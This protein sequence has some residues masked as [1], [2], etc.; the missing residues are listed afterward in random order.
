MA[1]K[2]IPEQRIVTCDGCGREC[3]P[4]FFRRQTKLSLTQRDLDYRGDAVYGGTRE[5]DL[6]DDCAKTVTLAID[7]LK[8][9][10]LAQERR[11]ATTEEAGSEGAR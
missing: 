4:S 6:C 3:T 5:M 9:D 7:G 2:T 1:T 10:R 11:K 8:A